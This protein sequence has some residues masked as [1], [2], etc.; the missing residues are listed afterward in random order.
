[1]S[2]RLIDT[3]ERALDDLRRFEVVTDGHFDTATAFTDG[4]LHERASDDCPLCRA[5]V[6]I[7]AF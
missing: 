4:F 3:R 2:T 5:T 7:P 6:P 1:M